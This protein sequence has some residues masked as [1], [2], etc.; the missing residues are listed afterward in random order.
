MIDGEFKATEPAMTGETLKTLNHFMKDIEEAAKDHVSPSPEWCAELYDVREQIKAL[1]IR[2]EKL[3]EVAKAKKDR[4]SFVHGGYMLKLTERAGSKTLDK[5]ALLARLEAE[6]GADEA[7]VYQE[8][9]TKQGKPSLVISVER[10]NQASGDPV[11]GQSAGE[12]L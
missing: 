8:A 12:G 3:L 5:D 11:G 2:E 1:K 6:L 4:G 7:K 10:I 9:C